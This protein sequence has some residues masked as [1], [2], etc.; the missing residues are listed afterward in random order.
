MQSILRQAVW[1]P[2]VV[3]L[4]VLP[5]GRALDAQ[6]ITVERFRLNPIVEPVETRGIRAS[7][8]GATIYGIIQNQL[9][10]IV[11]DSG[12]VRVRDL[13]DGRVVAETEVNNVAQFVVRGV[14]AG[15]YVAELVGDAGAVIATSGS[16]TAVAGAV[17][18]LP[19][20]VPVAPQGL[21]PSILGNA[22]SAAISSAASA[23][24]LAIDPGQPVSP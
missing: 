13:Y 4:L 16:F 11:P 20:I 21:L 2:V 12:D 22:T 17:I 8:K 10:A 23:G 15:V 5:G 9:G 1:G 6:P 14:A 18:Q 19:P 3:A 7:T 24:I